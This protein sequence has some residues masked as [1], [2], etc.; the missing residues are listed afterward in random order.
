MSNA[1]PFRTPLAFR[2]VLAAIVLALLSAQLRAADQWPQ[3]RGAGRDDISPE[4]GLL[5]QWPAAGPPLAWKIKG[6]GAGYSGVSI[7]GGRIY[8]MGDKDD[9]SQV[10]ALDE[11]DGKILWTAKVGKAG[12]GGGYPGPRC[13]PT[14]DGDLLY[15]MNQY[16]DL[17]CLQTADGKEVW[18]KNMKSD[19]NGGMMSGWGYSESPL[20]DGPNLVC[21]PG[22]PGGT[23]V[24]LNKKTGEL[25]WRSKDVKDPAAYSSLLPVE[26]GGVRQYVQLTGQSVFAVA[27]ADGRSLWYAPRKGQTAVITTPV[28]KDG[29]VFVSSGYKVGCNAFQ[30]TASGDTFS[31][32]EL[33]ANTNMTNHHGGL[34]L[35]GEYVYGFSDTSRTLKCMKLNTGDVVWEDKCVG[36]GSLTCADGHLYVRSESKKGSVAL[37]E[38]T[39]A[40][41]KETGRFDQPDRSDRSSWPHP[42]VCGGKLYLRDQDVLLCY[43]VKQP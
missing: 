1:R 27:A 33:Y 18:R 39:P 10:L 15:A 42:V 11:A 41:Y 4:T 22:G 30:V 32:K 5:K 2:I 37:V 29:V 24:A 6:L 21:T 3:F 31:A 17:V 13:T 38:A 35:I 36:K 14:L 43:N 8:T 16:G 7:A 28:F 26:F 34:V 40:G 9:T 19:F 20:V 23:V 25:V 12:A